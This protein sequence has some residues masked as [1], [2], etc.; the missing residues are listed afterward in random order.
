MKINKTLAI[1]AGGKSSRMNYNNKALLSYKEKTFIEN[2]IEAGKN[3]KK[4]VI[5]ANNKEIYRDF[6]V[7]VIS[8][9]YVGN[10]PL[11]G[12]HSALSYSDTDKVLCVACDMPLISKD[13]LEFLAN[14]KEEYEVLV[15][16]VND[17]LQ[18]LCSIYSK[19]I[20]GKIEKALENDD[21]KLQKLIYS[22]DYKEVHEKSL[23]EG[24]FFNI[25]TPDDYKRLEEIDNMYTVAIITSSD[26][27]YAGERED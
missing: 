1:M 5:V 16:R 17:R 12:I 18:P 22:L 15:P 7:D 26:K 10:G 23:T 21:N 20:L 24:E 27:G 25:N 4:V 3:F 2:I 14:V 13:T 11:S 19:K 8:D 6:N 9:I